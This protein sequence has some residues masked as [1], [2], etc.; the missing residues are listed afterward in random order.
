MLCERSTQELILGVGLKSHCNA[1][2]AVSE[3][4][5]LGSISEDVA[6]VP[7]ASLAPHLQGN[8][9]IIYRKLQHLFQERFS[10]LPPTSTRGRNGML[11]S[12]R[13]ST[14]LSTGLKKLGHPAALFRLNTLAERQLQS[15]ALAQSLV[16]CAV[17]CPTV[18]LGIAEVHW[19]ATARTLVCAPALLLLNSIRD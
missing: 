14:A 10:A 5:G 12:T 4:S 13:S 8:L 19:R 1:I 17:T 11:L 15:M 16:A 18:E 6:Q 2:H 9:V 3:T 7:L